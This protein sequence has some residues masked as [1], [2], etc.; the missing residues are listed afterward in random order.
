VEPRWSER[1]DSDRARREISNGVQPVHKKTAC[2][3][4][5]CTQNLLREVCNGDRV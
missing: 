2:G 4:V 1:R 3:A 5:E